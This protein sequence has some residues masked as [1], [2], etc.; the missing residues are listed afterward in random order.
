MINCTADRLRLTDIKP[1]GIAEQ[2]R[3]NQQRYILDR[4][5]KNRD[6]DC[7]SGWKKSWHDFSV[8]KN[9]GL[10]ATNRKGSIA[11]ELTMNQARRHLPP[12][13]R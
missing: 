3:R 2:D 11:M 9:V 8:I 1:T 6:A 4:G 7:Y 12:T 13:Y 10:L 5:V